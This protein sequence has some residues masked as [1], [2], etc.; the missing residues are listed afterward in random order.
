[1]ASAALERSASRSLRVPPC[2]SPARDAR[3]RALPPAVH[4]P[5]QGS[6]RTG[7]GLQVLAARGAHGL[8]LDGR[9]DD[10]SFVD[11]CMAAPILGVGG[12]RTVGAAVVQARAP[13]ARK[14]TRANARA[15]AVVVARK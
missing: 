3:P 9:L 12:C 4:F 8:S 15:G 6:M 1:M 2:E 7:S 10:G 14:E 11:G 13:P 5:L